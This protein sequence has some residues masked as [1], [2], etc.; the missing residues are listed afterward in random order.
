MRLR[1]WDACFQVRDCELNEIFV[2]RKKASGGLACVCFGWGVRGGFELK[3][4]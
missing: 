2:R 3:V 4:M 1:D